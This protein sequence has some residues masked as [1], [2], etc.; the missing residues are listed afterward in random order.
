[1]VTFNVNYEADMDLILRTLENPIQQVQ[2]DEKIAS[3]ILEDPYVLCW[4]GF[5]DWSVQVQIIAKTRPG[6]QWSVGRAVRK[7]GLDQLHEAGIRVAVPRQRIEN[8]A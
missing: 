7:A 8:V 3:V 2:A 6:K 4:T 1:M 5:T